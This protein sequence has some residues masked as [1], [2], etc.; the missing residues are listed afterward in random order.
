MPSLRF[1]VIGPSAWLSEV[2]S[3]KGEQAA[4]PQID[5]VEAWRQSA[6]QGAQG[7][8]APQTPGVQAP[9]LP[10]VPQGGFVSSIP[11]YSDYA[12][13]AQQ[14]LLTTKP[15]P[16]SQAAPTP[17]SAAP[18]PTQQS[19][20]P[21]G[22][23]A[24]SLPTIPQG[25]FAA[26]IGKL[27][28]WLPQ[29]P[30]QKQPAPTAPN[31]SPSSTSSTSRQ[32]SSA[33]NISAQNAPL[34]PIAEGD[35]EKFFATARPYADQVERETG[36][37]ATLSLAIAANETG[38]GQ[39]RYMAG[40]NNYHGIQSSDGTGVPYV[41][42]RP[43]ENGQEV[44]YGAR[45][46]EFETPLEGFRGFARFLTDNPRYAP[47]L[48]RY[49]QTGDV[50]QLAADIHQAGYAAD[51]SYTTK[52]QSI[53][54]GIPVSTGVG[55]VTDTRGVGLQGSSPQGIADG[56]NWRQTWGRNLSPNQ[57][58]ETLALGLSWDAAVA[59]CGIA[60]SI[61]F[62]RAAGRNPTFKEALELAQRT[63]EWNQ[64]AGMTHGSQGEVSLLRNLGVDARIGP[65]DERTIAA[66]IAAGKPVQLNAHGNGGHFYVATDVRQG[67]NGTEF[68]F[69]E[70]TSILKKS[71]GRQWFTLASLPDLGVGTPTESILLGS[72]PPQ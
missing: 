63:G 40:R 70:S 72:G 57:I 64:Y 49:R 61:A 45:Q 8:P 48:D 11:S 46:K 69:G 20:Q 65:V 27:E 24:P 12:Q 66:E 32:T 22:V 50:N 60:S 15:Q 29:T 6:I 59:T 7:Q 67:P 21:Q 52:I 18:V 58:D 71:G 56:P 19:Q 31:A 9:A 68:Y 62:A 2:A 14:A 53:I 34:G 47:A 13:Q 43:G 30:E 39:T 1:P 28:D 55:E 51:P 37:P 23:Q 25:G 5:Q 54:R 17:I 41:D 42:W 4:K 3:D 33:S 26:S 36:V 35:P 44:S 16:Q 10:G 38:Y